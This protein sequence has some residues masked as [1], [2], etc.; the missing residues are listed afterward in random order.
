VSYVGNRSNDPQI[1][2]MLD[3]IQDRGYDPAVLD[4]AVDSWNE[5]GEG[6]DNFWSEM[7]GPTI[8]ALE[9]RL[10][11]HGLHKEDKDAPA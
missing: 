11:Q 6:E 5:D 1:D 10:K 4:A 7:L 8:D 2:F 9:E 3:T